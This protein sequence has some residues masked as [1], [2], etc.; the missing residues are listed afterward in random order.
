MNPLQLFNTHSFD[1]RISLK[2]KRIGRWRQTFK[3]LVFKFN[4]ARSLEPIKFVLPSTNLLFRAE[5]KHTFFILLELFLRA[6]RNI[7]N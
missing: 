2:A 7:E 4:I 3:P 6:A 5:Q 1:Q